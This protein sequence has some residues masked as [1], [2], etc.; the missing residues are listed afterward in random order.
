MSRTTLHIEDHALS[1]AKA[2]AERH[3]LTLSQAVSDLIRQASKRPRVPE[4]G[5]GLRVL[6]LAKRSPRVASML[7][8]QLREEL[9]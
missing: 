8:D 5:S 3:H 1:V 2:H 7:V 9:P 6:R 4:A